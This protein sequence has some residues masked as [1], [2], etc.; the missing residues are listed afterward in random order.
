MNLP[1]T[2]H[3]LRLTPPKLEIWLFFGFGL[4]LR[5]YFFE[6]QKNEAK[7]FLPSQSLI[8]HTDLNLDDGTLTQKRF[9]TEPPYSHTPTT[10]QLLWGPQK[11]YVQQI[12]NTPINPSLRT[13]A[14][15]AAFCIN[16]KTFCIPL[17]ILKW[18][19]G[20]KTHQK[21]SP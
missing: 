4:F 19:K 21:G 17:N 20:L 3:W 15:K 12:K 2:S 13:N 18:L 16:A 7:I 6:P 8:G 11:K 1:Q 14:A 9:Y 5:F 10:T